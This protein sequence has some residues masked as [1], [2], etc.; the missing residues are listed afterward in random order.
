[1]PRQQRANSA[2]GTLVLSSRRSAPLVTQPGAHWLSAATP[3]L[4]QVVGGTGPAVPMPT[5]GWTAALAGVGIVLI[6]WTTPGT[7]DIV[8]SLEAFT[9]SVDGLPPTTSTLQNGAIFINVNPTV[10]PG[11]SITYHDQGIANLAGSQTT[12]LAQTVVVT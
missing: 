8:L 11:D 5:V 4:L 7:P 1:M 6:A 2:R 12:L 10:A 9:C 3:G